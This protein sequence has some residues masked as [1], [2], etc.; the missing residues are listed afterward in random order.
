MIFERRREARSEQICQLFAAIIEQ[1][2]AK[3]I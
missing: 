3:P 2:Q 1:A